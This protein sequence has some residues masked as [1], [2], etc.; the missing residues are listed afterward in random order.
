MSNSNDGFPSVR[1][2]DVFFVPFSFPVPSIY[3]LLAVYFRVLT[4]KDVTNAVKQ[5]AVVPSFAKS[6]NF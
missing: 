4:V 3:F 5:E 1:S 6:V 2:S